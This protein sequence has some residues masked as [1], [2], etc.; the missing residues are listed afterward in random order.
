M[1]FKINLNYVEVFFK[2]SRGRENKLLYFL[3]IIF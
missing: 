1:K 2:Y 3:L